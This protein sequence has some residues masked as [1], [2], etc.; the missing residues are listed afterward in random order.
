MAQVLVLA[1]IQ[2]TL[3]TPFELPDHLGSISGSFPSKDILWNV[4]TQIVTTRLSPRSAEI[5]EK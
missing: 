2:H 4:L 5:K 1:G 3:Y